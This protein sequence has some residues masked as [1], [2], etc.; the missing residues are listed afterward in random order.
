VTFRGERRLVASLWAAWAV[1][2]VAGLGLLA[3]ALFSSRPLRTLPK[4]PD[5][6]PGVE[7]PKGRPEVEA[8][9]GKRMSKG[10]AERSP[11]LPKAAAGPAPIDAVIRLKGVMDFGPTR[12][13][14]AVLELPGENKTKSFQAGDK[15]GQT[16]AVLKAVGE[17]VVV[18][19]ERRR[20]KLTYKGALELP[21]A[22][23][24]DNR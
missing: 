19:Y 1:A 2:G 24:G 12:G 16:G 13:A 17:T 15:I 10:V 21:A 22:A 9:A 18:E 6:A 11:E 3:F 23:V 7:V 20:W 4:L 8:L 14:M 5:L